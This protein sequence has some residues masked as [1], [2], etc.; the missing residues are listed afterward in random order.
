MQEA[1]DM[2]IDCVVTRA[3]ELELIASVSESGKWTHGL[4]KTNL[5]SVHA[6]PSKAHNDT[7]ISDKLAKLTN[8]LDSFGLVLAE[9][10]MGRVIDVV[11]KGKLTLLGHVRSHAVPQEVVCRGQKS[12]GEDGRNLSNLPRAILARHVL[13]LKMKRIV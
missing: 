5:V 4:E 10:Q 7:T 6:T 3:I 11:A 13:A 2:L 8:L 1:V 9:A 12:F